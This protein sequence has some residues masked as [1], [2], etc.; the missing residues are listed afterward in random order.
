M[1]NVVHAVVYRFNP[2]TDSAPR[3]QEYSVPGEGQM[4]VQ[5]VIRYIQKHM[6]PTLSFRNYNCYVGI[7]LGCAVKVNGKNV[8]ACSCLVNMGDTVTIEPFGG[9]KVIKDL[10]VDFEARE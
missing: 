9:A 6:D 5:A 8:R 1:T 2:T 7:C 10:V 4:S 3:L